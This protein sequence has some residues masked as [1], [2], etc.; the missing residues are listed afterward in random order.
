MNAHSSWLAKS[1]IAH[2]GLHDEHA[3]ENTLAAFEKAIQKGYA[4]ELD[5]RQ[6]SDD[7]IVVY[8]DKSLCRL[9]GC[10]GYTAGLEKTALD[11]LKI[12]NTNHT[13]P[14]LQ[15]VLDFVDGR[16]PLLIEIKNDTMDGKFEKDLLALL[17]NYKGDFAVQS[18]NPY[19]LEFC[20]KLAPQILRGQL[21]TKFDRTDK[22][23]KQE[24]KKLNKL[25]MLKISEPH[26]LAYDV[27]FLP[28]KFVTKAR[29]K[30]TLLLGWTIG[31]TQ[32]YE[33][34]KDLVDN[35]IFEGYEA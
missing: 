24:R 13:I 21:A 32:D 20:K 31:S 11:D 1:K 29:K 18:F 23:T 2:R 9:T 8:H 28:N 5:A 7:T 25:K 4:I 34:A 15:Q 14:T 6:I 10:D 27:R 30:G 22:H 17:G 19:S 26:F 3:P 35:I 12:C 33:R 16:T